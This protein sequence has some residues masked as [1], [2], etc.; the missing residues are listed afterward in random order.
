MNTVIRLAPNPNSDRKGLKFESDLLDV[1]E[2]V[3]EAHPRLCRLPELRA[4]T[5]RCSQP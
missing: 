4:V 2:E 3:Y 5:S 1:L